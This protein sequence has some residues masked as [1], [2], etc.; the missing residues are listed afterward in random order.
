MPHKERAERQITL[1]KAGVLGPPNGGAKS[2]PE[3]QEIYFDVIARSAKTDAL[4]S[5]LT[6]QWKFKDADPWHI[7]VRNGSSEAVAGVAESA[8]V[9][10][11]TTWP[12][13]VEISMRGESPAKA[14]LQRK[15]RP[16]GG[17]RNLRRMAQVWDP[18]QVN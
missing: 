7:K 14:V 8:D 12:E 10:L 2:S 6:V 16:K 11:Q 18:R 3:V 9:T 15:L 17:L 1:L 13:W 5:P 4:D